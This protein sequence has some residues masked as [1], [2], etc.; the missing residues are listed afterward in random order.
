[1]NKTANTLLKFVLLLCLAAARNCLALGQVQYVET[2]P[3]SG[4]FPICA[5][6]SVAT[7]YLDTNDF[8]GVLIAA[9]N[10]QK[11][12]SRVTGRMPKLSHVGENPGA[13]VILIGAI[14]KSRIIDQL[15]Q[16]GKIDVS[17]IANKWESY[18]T[19]VVPNPLPGV[20]NG[21]VIVGSDKR[22]TI[23]GIYDLSGRSAFRLGIIGRTCRPNITTNFLSALESLS[24]DRP[25]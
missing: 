22:G 13:N 12:I 16:D 17:S 6:N 3:G 20:A 5:G 24:K 25:R 7:I 23:Y 2:T 14:G 21:L 18:F 11:D 19:Q 10:L 1:M 15:I 9:D 8:A 4:S